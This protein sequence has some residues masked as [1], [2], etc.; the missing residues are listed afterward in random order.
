MDNEQKLLGLFFMD[1]T[2]LRIGNPIEERRLFKISRIVESGMWIEVYAK[3]D[4]ENEKEWLVCKANAARVKTLIYE[5]P[6][7][8]PIIQLLK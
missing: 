1:M 5:I 6:N 3:K 7:S 8:K 4:G 2:T